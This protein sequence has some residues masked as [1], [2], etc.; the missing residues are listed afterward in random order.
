MYYVGNILTTDIYFLEQQ[1][2]KQGE[3]NTKLL[4]LNFNYLLKTRLKTRL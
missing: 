4:F 3:D 1:N 2:K